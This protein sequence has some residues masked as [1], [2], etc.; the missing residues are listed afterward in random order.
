M[1]TASNLDRGE[2]LGRKGDVS[3][4]PREK[5][6]LQGQGLVQPEHGYVGAMA[7]EV[8]GNPHRS[9]QGV[10]VLVLVIPTASTSSPGPGTEPPPQQ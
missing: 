10:V 3:T 7:R 8:F 9:A 6:T 2:Q 5:D 4:D 1:G